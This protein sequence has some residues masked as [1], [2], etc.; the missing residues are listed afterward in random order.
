MSKLNTMADRKAALKSMYG[1]EQFNNKILIIGYGSIGT[2]ILPLLIKIVKM[3]L[4]QITII[5]KDK[6]RFTNI[7]EL[8][9]INKI[10]KSDQKINKVKVKLDRLNIKR[11]IIDR[12]KMGQDDLIIDCSYEISTKFMYDLCAE[13]GISYTN[14]AVEVWED[15]MSRPMAEYS[16][17]NLMKE[18]EDSDLQFKKKKNNFIYGLGCNPGNV[19]IWTMYALDKIKENTNKNLKSDSYADLAN[20][21]GL[22]VVHVAEVD[23]QITN[24]PKRDNEYVNTWSSDGASWFGEAYSWIELGWGTHEKT[25]PASVSK[26]LHSDVSITIERLGALTWARSYT[27]INK[28]LFGLMIPHEE[29]Y[30]IARSLS[31]RDSKNNIIYKPSCYY[32]YKP[33]DSSLAS[34]YEIAEKMDVNNFNG[35]MQKNKRLMTDDIIEGK[36]ELGCT[37]FFNNGE[38]YW[39]GSLLDIEEARGL[40]DNKFDS[41]INAT[42]MQVLAG[43][44]GGILYLIKNIKKKEYSGLLSPQDLPI[45]Q[46][47]KWTRPLLG[48]FVCT[49]VK[50]WTVKARDG[51]ESTWQFEDFAEL[52]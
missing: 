14:S 4:S 30:S 34:L 12:L 18:V 23:S 41:I 29:C 26:D 39:V 15:D 32:V 27:P 6:K 16:Y 19:N 52:N 7:K 42:L 40:Y 33:C 38:I 35:E 3:D 37:L 31:L 45:H 25:M 2:G 50:D 20:K 11:I 8:Y 24:N 43:Y 36:D 47:M 22:R 49:K 46:F 28:N 17:A 21:L 51:K 5:E 48:P 13:H 10:K 1:M 9:K 44:M